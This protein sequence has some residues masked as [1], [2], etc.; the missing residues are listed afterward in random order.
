MLQAQYLDGM[1]LERE[2]GITIKLNTARMK[3][4]SAGGCWSPTGI[5]LNAPCGVSMWGAALLLLLLLPLPRLL[6]PMQ[7]HKRRNSAVRT[8]LPCATVRG[9]GWAD[10]CPQ[11]D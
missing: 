7:Q 11:P 1:D 10:V 6:L 3:V 5:T 8:P 2:R 9:Q 4:G